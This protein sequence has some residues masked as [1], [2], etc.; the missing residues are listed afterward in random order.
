MYQASYV[1]D[2]GIIKF[3]SGPEFDTS[4]YAKLPD[5]YEKLKGQRQAALDRDRRELQIAV[6]E[7]KGYFC[8]DGWD[9]N[10]SQSRF[11]Q[12]EQASQRVW[13]KFTR[14][15]KNIWRTRD[16]PK[17]ILSTT[18]PDWVKAYDELAA[19][20][21]EVPTL[22]VD[23]WQ[24][25]GGNGY[26]AKLP[27]R[28]LEVQRVK[29]LAEASRNGIEAVAL[30]QAGILEGLL[31]AMSVYADAIGSYLDRVPLN[32]AQLRAHFKNS[33]FDFKWNNTAQ[34]SFDFYR[35]TK[36]VT[37]YLEQMAT[38][39]GIRLDNQVQGDWVPSSEEIK[40]YFERALTAA[41]SGQTIGDFDGG[42]YDPN[43]DPTNVSDQDGEK[44]VK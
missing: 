42:G 31:N 38:E 13:E 3:A 18:Y 27:E 6:E 29:S 20:E 21:Q 12:I 28:L 16:N 17:T 35:R 43:F 34:H 24:G 22:T 1:A 9:K 15:Y 7:L 37:A 40:N 11:G 41:K 39:A 32:E 36:T 19:I 33:Y 10:A 44:M 30:L 26:R 5:L 23:S 25:S 2:G 8:S 14:H 4:Q